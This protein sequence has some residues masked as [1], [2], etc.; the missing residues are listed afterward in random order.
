ML[1]P[2]KVLR[3]MTLTC[4]KNILSYCVLILGIGISSEMFLG[5]FGFVRLFW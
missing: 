2:P 1:H 4:F 5:A 3:H